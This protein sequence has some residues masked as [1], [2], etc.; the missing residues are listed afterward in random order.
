MEKAVI[1]TEQ[2]QISPK[3]YKEFSAM[4]PKDIPVRMPHAEFRRI[5]E[6]AQ[7]IVRTG[8]FTPYSNMILVAGVLF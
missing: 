2:E 8:E 7:A 6:G 4:W 3:M 1:D 5:A